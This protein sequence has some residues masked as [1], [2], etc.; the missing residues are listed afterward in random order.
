MVKLISRA[1]RRATVRTRGLS[2][3]G[4]YPWLPWWAEVRPEREVHPHVDAEHA[5]WFQA[6]NAGTTE[7]E[8]LNWL[9]A[10]VML[11]KP[12][13][14]LETG[15]AN[16]VGTLALASAC[17]G[18]G[19][20]VVH[21]VELLPE[22]CRALRSRLD[23]AGLAR[24]GEVHCES[25]MDYLARTDT[26]FDVGFFDSMCELRAHECRLAL[27]R[28]LLTRLAVFHDTSP[29]RTESLVGFP[30]P[31]DHVRYRADV[32]E[33]TRHPRCTGFF[34]SRLSRGVIALFFDGDPRA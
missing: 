11:L 14:V 21:S 7:L 34:E 10:T 24:F 28:G 19:F 3:R 30:S 33:L 25:S 20:G 32:M 9:H 17:R 18:N 4:R 1:F 13:N 27:D 5:E 22:L 2:S 6:H 29:L 15:A 26:V 23:A 16:G 31:E 8:V 12:R